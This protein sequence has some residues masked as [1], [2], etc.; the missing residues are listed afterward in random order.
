[1]ET[2]YRIGDIKTPKDAYDCLMGQLLSESGNARIEAFMQ[3]LKEAH[4]FSDRKNYTLLKRKFKGLTDKA[5]EA[6]PDELIRELDDE[7]KNSGAYF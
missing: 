4:I 5:S 3:E 7:V 2:I 1:M 6:I